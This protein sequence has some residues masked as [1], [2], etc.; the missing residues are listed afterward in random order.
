[1]FLRYSGPRAGIQ[2]PVNHD[3]IACL[4]SRMWSRTVSHVKVSQWVRVFQF[5]LLRSFATATCRMY[6]LPKA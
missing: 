5:L 3:W 6:N 2:G 4:V 1:M